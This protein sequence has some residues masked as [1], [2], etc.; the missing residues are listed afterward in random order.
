MRDYLGERAVEVE[1]DARGGRALAER[2]EV[3][4]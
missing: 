3:S 2:V 1:Q 4:P